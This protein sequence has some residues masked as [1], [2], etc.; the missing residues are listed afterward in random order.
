MLVIQI[1]DL[2]FVVFL[3]ILWIVLEVHVCVNVRRRVSVRPHS[4]FCSRLSLVCFLYRSLNP[5]PLDR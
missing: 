1:K 4:F 2:G 5:L 3:V